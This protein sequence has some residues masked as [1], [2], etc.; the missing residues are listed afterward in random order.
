MAVQTV[1][2][3]CRRWSFQS[4]AQQSDRSQSF[5]RVGT[6]VLVYL[7]YDVALF[8]AGKAGCGHDVT[9]DIGKSCVGSSEDGPKMSSFSSSEQNHL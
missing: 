4:R 9:L 1:L 5:N 3:S 2:D 7:C 6:A 8:P